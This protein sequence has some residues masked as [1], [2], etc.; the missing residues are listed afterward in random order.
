MTTMLEIICRDPIVSR[1]GRPFGAGQGNRMRSAGWPLPSVVAGSLRSTLG[2]VAKRDFSVVTV[3]ELL[4]V[5]VA[6]LFP[7]ADGDLY[8]PAPQD[9]VVHPDRGPLRAAPQPI[10]QAGCDWPAAGL[11]PV[12]LTEA[13]APENFK[14][15]QG[16]VWWPSDRY[17]GWLAGEDIAFDQRFLKAPEVEERT[18]VQLDSKTGA[19][20]EGNLFSTAA[21]PLTHLA[22]Y[23]APSEG[24]HSERFAEIK[25]ATRVRASQWC[26]ETVKKLD[27]VHPLGGERRLVHWRATTGAPK[28][29]CPER[30]SAALAQARR[31]RMVLATPAIFRD[32]WKPGWV[33]D[34]MLGTPPGSKNILKLV[35]VSIQRWQAVSGWSLAKLPGQPRGPKPVKR[36]VPAGG[37]YFF[38]TVDK[39]DPADLKKCWLEPVSDNEQD[40]RDGFGL[41][42]WGI[43]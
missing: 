43:W 30:V 18:H 29:D 37:V 28:W 21:L 6:G 11:L 35:G 2:K 33:N 20:D 17:A 41:A 19:A 8:L 24:T 23:G 40:R 10:D 4:Q 15:V 16:P 14:P 38:E 22:R 9:C 12:D 1:D 36:V 26:A 25:L 31:V 7:V 34:R 39:A 3:Q 27:T 5:E 32:G 13:Q 42:L